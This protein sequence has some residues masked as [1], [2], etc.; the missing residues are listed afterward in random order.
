M[1]NFCGCNYNQENNDS[2]TQKVKYILLK[3]Q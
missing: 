1:G 3:N 2:Q